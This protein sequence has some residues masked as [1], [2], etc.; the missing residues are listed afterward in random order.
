MNLSSFSIYKESL[1]KQLAHHIIPECIDDLM[2]I[3]IGSWAIKH[4]LAVNTI[5]STSGD[6]SLIGNCKSITQVRSSV[7]RNY[8]SQ[9]RKVAEH[10][11]RHHLKKDAGIPSIHHSTQTKSETKSRHQGSTSAKYV[12]T[13]IDSGQGTSNVERV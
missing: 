7:T 6:E 5:D 11:Q 13:T 9:N 8:D 4:T 12:A 2:T 1:K 10:L 3:P